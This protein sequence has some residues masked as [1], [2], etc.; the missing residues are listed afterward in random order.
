MR[1]ER[2][3]VQTGWLIGSAL[4]CLALLS[5]ATVTGKDNGYVRTGKNPGKVKGRWIEIHDIGQLRGYSGVYVGDIEVDIHWKKE[6]RETPIDEELLKDK[7]RE[8]LL[9]NLRELSVFDEVSERRPGD[10]AD[11]MVRLDCDLLVEPG[12]RAVRYLVGFGA[13]KSK[14]ILEIHL[15]DHQTGEEL[16][17]YHGYGTGTG[18]GFKLG[19]GGARKMTQDDI[20]ENAKMF[21]ELLQAEL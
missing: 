7:I 21:A 17:R 2:S 3:S 4:L 16:G 20:Q 6:G 19:G 5:P 15:N 13:G 10:D 9:L 12:N 14:S 18:M 11:G 8:H 1:S